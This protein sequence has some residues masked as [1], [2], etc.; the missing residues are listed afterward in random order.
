MK[1]LHNSLEGIFH[2]L[3][4]RNRVLTHVWEHLFSACWRL[5]DISACSM[6]QGIRWK[7]LEGQYICSNG[8]WDGK[9]MLHHTCSLW[10]NFPSMSGGKYSEVFLLHFLL[11]SQL[12]CIHQKLWYLSC[13]CWYDSLMRERTE[14]PLQAVW[15]K[16]FENE[17]SKS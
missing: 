15:V 7:S 13:C 16:L 10:P 5:L 6:P 14:R 12:V 3:V 8:M 2:D 1:E 11:A 17:L 9:K 4:I